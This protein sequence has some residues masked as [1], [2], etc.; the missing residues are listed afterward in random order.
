MC[1]PSSSSSATQRHSKRRST[2]C[3]TRR[4]PI[5][6]STGRVPRS[7]RSCGRRTRRSTPSSHGS[8]PRDFGASSR[9]RAR[10]CT[11]GA[12]SAARP[13][14]C[15]RPRT[16]A[17]ARRRGGR[18]PCA[19]RGRTRYQRQSPLRR[20]VVG[21]IR[22]RRRAP[23]TPAGA[24]SS[25]PPPSSWPH[26][27]TRST[28]RRSSPSRTRGR[29]ADRAQRHCKRGDRRLPQRTDRPQVGP[30]VP[31]VERPVLGFHALRGRRVRAHR[32]L[33]SGRW[34]HDQGARHP[35]RV[36][37]SRHIPHS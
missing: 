2:A 4:A 26:S 7:L 8:P 37:P 10:S 32:R 34:S 22:R 12:R 35:P 20:F 6:G 1:S 29:A 14:C 23:A 30:P 24:L 36:A 9:R 11:C 31:A 18:A 25:D 16:G 17:T 33:A 28:R 27:T 19:P 3:R 5:T 13:R 21:T 15:A